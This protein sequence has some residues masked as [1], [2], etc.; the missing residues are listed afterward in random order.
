MENKEETSIYR[1][2]GRRIKINILPR[3]KRNKKQLRDDKN[4]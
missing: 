3:V 2:I 4:E 1:Y